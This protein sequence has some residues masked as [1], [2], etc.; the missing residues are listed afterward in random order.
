M[1][2]YGFILAYQSHL[3]CKFK[4]LIFEALIKQ[5]LLI[6]RFLLSAPLLLIAREFYLFH[7]RWIILL[8]RDMIVINQLCS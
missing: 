7:V 8:L 2:Q 1:R 3:P 5:I 6:L 4:S